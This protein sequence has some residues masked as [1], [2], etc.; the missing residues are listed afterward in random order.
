MVM[1]TI[2]M[3]APTIRDAGPENP[4]ID[5][6][7]EHSPMNDM[8]P[9]PRGY[10]KIPPMPKTVFIGT[11]GHIDHG[12]SSL[13]RALTGTDPDRLKEEKERGITIELGFAHLSL[14][15][16]TLA[17]IVDVPGHERFVRTMVAGAAGVDIVLLVV[18]AAGGGSGDP[19]RGNGRKSARAPGPRRP[20]GAI[21][22]G[23]PHRGQPAGAGEGERA[24]RVGPVPPR[25]VPPHE[26]RGSFR[27]VP[28]AGP[29]A[30]TAPR[31]GLLPRGD[32]LLRRQDPPLRA[33]RNP[34]GRSE[35]H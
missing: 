17:G 34:A 16:G 25:H 10:D 30:A 23:D 27:G 26:A 31:P 4:K 9:H 6:S 33:G 19:P 18:P 11:A 5:S 29:Q 24:A 28:P 3:A 22:R 15:S 1:A 7:R 32:L 35:E 20:G 13:V 2:R 21:V 12:K 14:P 8:V